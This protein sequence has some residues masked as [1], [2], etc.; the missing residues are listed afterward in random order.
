MRSQSKDRRMTAAGNGIKN[1][2][3]PRSPDR[4]SGSSTSFNFAG[5]F[6]TNDLI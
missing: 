3:K 5:C 2:A 4:T 1:K 6:N